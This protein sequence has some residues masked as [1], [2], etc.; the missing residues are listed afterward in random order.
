MRH[1]N[2]VT[3]QHGLGDDGWSIHTVHDDTELKSSCAWLD[4]IQLNSTYGINNSS[5]SFIG[6]TLDIKVTVLRST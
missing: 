3:S 1:V 6:G 4:E 5:K 2:C